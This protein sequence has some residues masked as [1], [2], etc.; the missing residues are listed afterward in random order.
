MEIINES[1]RDRA[2][3][4]EIQPPKTLHPRYASD[5]KRQIEKSRTSPMVIKVHNNP[6][7]YT[8]MTTMSFQLPALHEASKSLNVIF[9]LRLALITYNEDQAIQTYFHVNQLEY[10]SDD[11][12]KLKDGT[13]CVPVSN[14]EIANRIK[15]YRF[16]CFSFLI[17]F[18]FFFQTSASFDYQRKTLSI[19]IRITTISMVYKW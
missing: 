13:I 17:A 3:V 4:V 12:C 18:Y 14:F 19:Q 10:H 9:L 1:I 16:T 15:K 2:M 7:L 8:N 6:S 11:V 5:G